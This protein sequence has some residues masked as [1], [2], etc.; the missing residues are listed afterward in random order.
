M[1]DFDITFIDKNFAGWVISDDLT[2]GIEN[3]HLIYVCDFRTNDHQ[4]IG[5]RKA[6]FDTYNLS[7]PIESFC[8]SV[9]ELTPRSIQSMLT[10]HEQ[11]VFHSALVGYIKLTQ[12]YS[13][14]RQSAQ[15]N[16]TLH[17][18]LNIYPSTNGQSPL[19]RPVMTSSD[20]LI[21]TVDHIKE[22]SDEVRGIDMQNHPEW[23]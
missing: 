6:D 23:F 11:M 15:E 18:I 1:S 20:E 4:L 21:M 10:P 12:T 2:D 9:C 5:I 13:V 14:W 7:Y 16:D 3:C 8:S 22:I 19:L 17:A